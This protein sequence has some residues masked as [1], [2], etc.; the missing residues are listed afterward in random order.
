M[1]LRYWVCTNFLQGL[2]NKILVTYWSSKTIA[3]I[4]PE[5]EWIPWK[6]DRTQ[7]G[8]WENAENRQKFL[9]WLFKELRFKSM[10]D[11]YHISVS[12]FHNNGGKGYKYE[13]V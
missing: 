10:E 2:S 12:D 1:G 3:A 9:D 7:K 13:S 5:H 8:F 11:W 6:F 4:F